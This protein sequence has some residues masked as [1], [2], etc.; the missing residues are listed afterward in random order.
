[1]ENS[2]LFKADKILKITETQLLRTQPTFTLDYSKLLDSILVICLTSVE[3]VYI[4]QNGRICGESR[5]GGYDFTLHWLI[6]LFIITRPDDQE[7]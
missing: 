2:F 6:L 5:V 4:I 3:S 1:M 7:G